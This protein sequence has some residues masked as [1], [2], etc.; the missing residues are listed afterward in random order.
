[1]IRTLL[2]T[3]GL[4]A[5][6]A[7]PAIYFTPDQFREWL[8]YGLIV[9]AC[10]GLLRWLPAA[11]R[12]YVERAGERSSLGILGVVV[13]LASICFWQVYAVYNIRA[14]RPDW[15]LQTH[16][17]NAIVYLMLIGVVL[18]VTASKFHGETPT[19]AGKTATAIIA[20]L[21]LFFTSAGPMVLKFIGGL[22]Q[23]LLSLLAHVFP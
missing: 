19:R 4:V 7:L 14:D 8:S 12:V 20:T 2:V 21:G 18:F 23:S 11:T 15:L 17:F 16:I 3:L 10:I 13:V 5:A 6:F 22:L 1:M 9:A